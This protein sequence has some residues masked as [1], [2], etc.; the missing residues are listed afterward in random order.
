MI[1]L[2]YYIHFNYNF[3]FLLCIAISMTYNIFSTRVIVRKY[4]SI[5][6]YFYYAFI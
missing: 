1:T 5:P 6:L 4:N 3:Y 2:T